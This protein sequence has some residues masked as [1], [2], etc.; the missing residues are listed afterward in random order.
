MSRTPISNNLESSILVVEDDVSLLKFFEEALARAGFKVYGA[1]S[2][3]DAKAIAEHHTIDLAV[4]DVTLPDMN[5]IDL[6]KHL[7]TEHG[8]PFI[9]VTGDSERKTIDKAVEA[10]AITYLVK[11]VEFE[12]LIPAVE[13][14]MRRASEI[15]KLLESVDKL[16][17]ASEKRRSISMAVGIIMERFGIT[18]HQAFDILRF[19]AR[20]RQEQMVIT[21][22]D[23]ISGERGF[24]LLVKINKYLSRFS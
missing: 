11:P 1:I 23:I 17:K 16:S 13:T 24:D 15:G 18:E 20:S 21:S 7:A 9:Q 6:G 5:G 4:L 14:A 12:Q 3:S 10:G 8:I 2:G 19:L 22:R